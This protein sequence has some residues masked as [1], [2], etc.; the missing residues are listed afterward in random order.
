MEAALDTTASRGQT[1]GFGLAKT[2]RWAPAGLLPGWYVCVETC[3]H[4]IPIMCQRR[5]FY[6]WAYTSGS[7]F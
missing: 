5:G 1:G 2:S 4:I 6:G 7:V 3:V